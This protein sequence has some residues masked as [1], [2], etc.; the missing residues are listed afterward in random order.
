MKAWQFR[1]KTP[2]FGISR[3][4]YL[5]VLSGT[6]TLPSIDE[7]L[8][9]K[10]MGDE[11]EGLGAPL[12]GSATKQD[13]YRPMERGAYALSTKD[14]KTV[15]KLLVLPKEE[16]GYDPEPVLRSSFASE[17]S[18]ETRDRIS[19]TWTLLQMTFETHHPMVY[20]SVRFALRIAQRLALLSSG[21][22]ADPLSQT[23]KLPEEV[24]QS[25]QADPRIDARDVVR[26]HRREK[27]GEPFVHTLGLLKFALPEVELPGIDSSLEV[28][29]TRFLYSLT[30]KILLGNV[31]SPGDSVGSKASPF[32]VANGGFDRGQWEGVPVL[33]LLP[34]KG[35][36]A[37]QALVSWVSE[38]P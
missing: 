27:G 34:P 25:P 11:V 37:D 19:A 22:I 13:I 36:T 38:H 30:Q 14:R 6:A 31:L 35:K 4:F 21:V 20:D 15:M 3:G 16:A 7:V 32:V 26:V 8:R 33:D 17:L 10:P 2:G 28:P 1:Q 5:S 9:P 24:F 18:Q 23:Y 12:G 29:A